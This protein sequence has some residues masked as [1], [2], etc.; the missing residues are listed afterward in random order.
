M[1]PCSAPSASPCAGARSHPNPLAIRRKREAMALL[2]VEKK[3]LDM[4]P[5]NR[6]RCKTCKRL[7]HRY[8]RGGRTVAS[9][10]PEHEIRRCIELLR[11][12]GQAKLVRELLAKEGID[13]SENAVQNRARE[14]RIP[15]NRRGEGAGRPPGTNKSQK[16]AK[17]IE[18]LL[19]KTSTAEIMEKCDTAR[20]Y[21]SAIRIQIRAEL[22]AKPP[23]KH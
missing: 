18:L 2:T 14:E 6:G 9:Y 7:P 5:A 23:T 1:W 11:E 3:S 13:W 10:K 8:I 4:G 15:L 20:A 22:E 12:H 21:V 17:I 16:R 19:K